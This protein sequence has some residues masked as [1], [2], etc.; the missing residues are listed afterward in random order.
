MKVK[1][2]VLS[3]AQYHSA[4]FMSLNVFVLATGGEDEAKHDAAY[5]TRCEA[6]DPQSGVRCVE[7]GDQLGSICNP[8]LY[9]DPMSTPPTCQ[10]STWV[11][12]WFASARFSTG[13]S[14]EI[15][16]PPQNLSLWIQ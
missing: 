7:P 13:L 8:A 10:V 12:R 2:V 14:S 11:H 6:S 4:L 5:Q 1:N 3:L 15:L 9:L 16:S